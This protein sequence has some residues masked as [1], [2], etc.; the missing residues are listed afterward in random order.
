M[1]QFVE[2][3]HFSTGMVEQF[4]RGGTVAFKLFHAVALEL[5]GNG[6]LGTDGRVFYVRIVLR[7]QGRLL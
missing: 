6:T 3:F 1:E 7:L 2:P 5:Q 4:K